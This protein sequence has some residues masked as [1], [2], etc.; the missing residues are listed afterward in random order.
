M[1]APRKAMPEGIH[2]LTRHLVVHGA[3]KAIAFYKRAF[4]AVERFRFNHPG[5]KRI[6][7]AHLQIGDSALFLA[8]DF[9]EYGGSCRTPAELGGTPVSIHLYVEDV[10]ATFAQAVAAGATAVMPPQDMFWGDR[11]GRLTDPFG[12][13]WSIATHKRTPSEAEMRAGAEAAFG[14]MAK[15][16]AEA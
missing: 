3:D 1:K 13:S 2:T 5:D 15:Q 14:R 4:G 9:P 8:D 12:H 16:K 7:H 10:D 6:G 11:Y